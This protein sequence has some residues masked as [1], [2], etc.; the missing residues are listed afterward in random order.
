MNKEGLQAIGLICNCIE[1]VSI[2]LLSC[3]FS[4]WLLFLLFVLRV[5][6]YINEIAKDEKGRRRK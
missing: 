1:G 2:L 6:N 4:Y 3:L 5:P